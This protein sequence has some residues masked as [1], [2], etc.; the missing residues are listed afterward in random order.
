MTESTN[1][2]LFITSLLEKNRDAKRAVGMEAYMKNNFTCLGIDSPTR[3]LL[4]QQFHQ[5]LNI[6][7][8]NRDLVSSLWILPDREYQYVAMDHLKKFTKQ[9][10]AEDISWIET[11]ITTKS[12]WDTV[13]F[14]AVHP[15]GFICKNNPHIITQRVEKWI[16]SD[17]IWLIRTAILFQLKFKEKLD[18][19]LVQK[20]ILLHDKSKEFFINKAS[21]WILREYAKTNPFEVIQFVDANPQLS[22]LTKREALK[23]QNK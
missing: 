9:L 23:H 4:V 17:N 10:K 1:P 15:V 16:N 5:K 3:K 22:N 7:K 20:Y 18:F 11:L 2:L 19:N 21:G 14:L 13:D 12:W 6:K 8:L